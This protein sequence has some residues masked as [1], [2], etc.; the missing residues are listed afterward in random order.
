MVSVIIPS[1]NRENTIVRAVNSVLNQTYKDIEVIV[2]DDCSKDRT[3]EL[4][5]SIKDERLKFFKLEKN[6]GAC[7][8]R[9]FGIEK[10]NGEFIAFQDSDDEWLP[11]KLEKQMKV[12]E[13]NSDVDLVFCQFTKIIKENTSV[14]PPLESGIITREILLEKSYISTQTLIGRKECFN[15]I[16]F[17]PQMPRLQDHDLVI[18]LSKEYR[19]YFV[20]EPLVNMYVQ[21][22][23]ISQN[24]KKLIDAEYLLLT[25]YSEEVA[26]F[27]EFKYYNLT[28]FAVMKRRNKMK[29][30]IEYKALYKMKPSVKR[31]LKYIYVAIT[32][33]SR[34]SYKSFID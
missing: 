17:D 1:Y 33:I 23:S 16:K 32:D 4:L 6:S 28:I 30:G 31:L 24:I 7:V 15:T 34:K 12:F 25:K 8:A 14:F 20:N 3:L 19:F 9:N 10:A 11:E 22:D 29:A 5:S 13:S 2:V 21:D 27:P 26:S 18:R